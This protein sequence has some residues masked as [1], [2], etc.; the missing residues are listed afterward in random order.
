[1]AYFNPRPVTFNP[2]TKVIEASGAM[3]KA[4]YDAFNDAFVQDMTKKQ[5]EQTVFK[6]QWDRE[7]DLMTQA[8]N[9]DK[10]RFDQTKHGDDMEY[11][12]TDLNRKIKHDDN[13][14][15]YWQGNLQN[16]AAR[17]QIANN[18]LGFDKSKWADEHS[19]SELQTNLAFN[20]L[21]GDK[22][23]KS[24]FTQEQLT[25]MNPNDVLNLRRAYVANNTKNGDVYGAK[26]NILERKDIGQASW[27]AINNSPDLQKALGIT[28]E[29][30]KQ[31]KT[32]E[33]KI[34]FGNQIATQLDKQSKVNATLKASG[35]TDRNKI[36]QNYVQDLNELAAAT[37]LLDQ[38][39]GIYDSSYTGWLD[40]GF[41]TMGGTF[42]FQ[43][44]DM[45]SFKSLHSQVVGKLKPL[46]SA[47]GKTSNMQYKDLLRAIVTGD[48][49][50]DTEYR[51]KFDATIDGIKA[52][53]VSTIKGMELAGASTGDLKTELE[54]N[55]QWLDSLKFNRNNA[56]TP[57]AL[58]TNGFSSYS[59][60][61]Q[62]PIQQSI[63]PQPNQGMTVTKNGHKIEW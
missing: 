35:F 20:E 3:G 25:R 7:N 24:N 46:S 52:S 33:Q 39:K 27:E 32:P 31:Y 63:N 45:A 62:P 4:L 61:P 1:M 56:A 54:G 14:N 21:G 12:Y 17:N 43:D 16:S 53:M 22:W 40:R 2:D 44:A 23:I 34:D 28:P 47:G 8:L 11:K 58:N 57:P 48:E 15:I 49:T 59:S 26:Q 19:Q 38:I 42:D 50:S 13:Q 37:K 29:A 36:R 18:R 60:S 5:Y 41:H 6:N 51:Q 30:L 55:L 9:Q 10:H